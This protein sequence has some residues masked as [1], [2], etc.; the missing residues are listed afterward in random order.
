MISCKSLLLGLV[1]LLPCAAHADAPSLTFSPMAPPP[2]LIQNG[3]FNSGFSHWILGGSGQ[4]VVT[5]GGIN[6]VAPIG[7]AHQAKLTGYTTP[8]SMI[9]QSVPLVVGDTYDLS[10]WLAATGTAAKSFE[11]TD[12]NRNVL[13]IREGGLSG[14]FGYTSY[15]AI[16]TAVRANEF[17]KFSWASPLPNSGNAFYLTGIALTQQTPPPPTLLATLAGGMMGG[18][19]MLRARRRRTVA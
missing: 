13:F 18:I 8:F 14:N 19:R 15:S 2:N 17:L 10:F 3:S 11:V 1:L 6:P 7:L 9:G 16:F 12:A 5:S 4:S